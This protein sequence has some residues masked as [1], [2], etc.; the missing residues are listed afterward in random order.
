MR[1]ALLT[2]L[3]LQMGFASSYA[4]NNAEN[5]NTAAQNLPELEEM[6]AEEAAP[7]SETFYLPEVEGTK[8]YAGKKTTVA[9][10]DQMPPIVDQ[11]LRETFVTIPG[12]N[13][14]ERAIPSNVS[15]SYRGL[16]DPHESEDVLTMQ[17][18]IPLQSDWFGYSA[19]YYTPPIESVEKIEFIRGGG[20]LLYGPQIGP[21]INYVTPLP[22]TDTDFSNTSQFIGGS[23]GLYS[24]YTAF[25]GTTNDL[26][27][28][29]DFSVKGADGKRA[30][31]DYLV[32]SG[33]LTTTYPLSDDSQIRFDF[34][35]YSS[36][37]GEAGTLSQAQYDA[38]RYLTTT[39]VNRIW[40]DRYFPTLTYNKEFSNDALLEVK[41]WGGYQDRF[42]RRA[43]AGSLNTNLD[44]REFYFYGLDTRYRRD[45]VGAGSDDNT[46]TAG[47]T[48]YYA[49][50]PRTRERGFSTGTTGTDVFKVANS[51]LYGAM[52]AENVFRYGDF[53]V[54]PS[55]R[56][57]VSSLES[58][59]EFN[60][61]VTRPLFDSSETAVVPLGGLGFTYD[62]TENN[63]A[64]L[65]L[66]TSYSPK[67]YGDLGNPTSNT[68][69]VADDGTAYNFQ[70]ELGTRG[71]PTSYLQYDASIFFMRLTDIVESQTLLNGDQLQANAGDANYFGAEAAGSFDL[72]GFID[73]QNDTNYVDQIG[74]FS[75]FANT[76][77]LSAE[78]TSGQF[79]GNTP[80]H[81]PAMLW[82]WGGIWDWK[83]RVRLSITGQFNSKQYWQDS[84]TS[85]GTVPD[86]IPAYMVWDMSAEFIVTENISILGGINNL[87][88]ANYYS[89]I[90]SNGIDPLDPRN[91]WLGAR[92]SF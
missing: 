9:V 71:S 67:D 51:T 61:G 74:S 44:R 41:T 76:S 20:A 78:F 83:D 65:N 29:A 55:F 24:I 75:L 28:F 58:K 50:A 60:T 43:S 87:F 31:A 88:N 80:S 85:N 27:Y 82:K 15:I 5:S 59:E 11:D 33:N 91:F 7:I 1:T 18:G 57:D 90:R 45:W 46:L 49:D 86:Q 23:A 39:P 52:F 56:L 21:V 92:A 54:I 42:S 40:I 69:R 26:G 13:V 37:S 81:A 32:F 47:F 68:A 38:D 34:T 3:A 48:F 10:L 72:I 12:I 36:N 6:Q 17:N 73:E 62:Y 64:Y 8:V 4:Q 63:Q 79:N 16:G 14:T 30:N 77:L 89:R 66:S 25:S 84:N 22:R 70:A 2:A 35:G 53:A 19:V